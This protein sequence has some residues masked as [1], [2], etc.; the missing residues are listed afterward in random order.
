MEERFGD[1]N[2]SQAM[3]KGCGFTVTYADECKRS[4]VRSILHTGK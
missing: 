3:W 2:C 4:H 1:F